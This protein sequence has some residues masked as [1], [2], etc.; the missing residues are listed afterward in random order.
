[1]EKSKTLKENIQWLLEQYKKELAIE[2]QKDILE[3][4]LDII[5]CYECTISELEFALKISK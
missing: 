3:Q 5:N 4:N 2:N 1:M